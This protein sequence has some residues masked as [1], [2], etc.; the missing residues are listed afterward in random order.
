MEIRFDA[1]PARIAADTARRT[2]TG[3]VVPWGTFAAVSTGQT[4]A[5]ARGSPC[6]CRTGRN[7]SSI[8]TRPSQSRVYVSSTD[9][10]RGPGGHLPGTGRRRW[11]SDARRGRRRPP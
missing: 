10:E 7:W 11:R 3:L 5:F 2:I 4:V 6:P 8:T 1:P 9:T